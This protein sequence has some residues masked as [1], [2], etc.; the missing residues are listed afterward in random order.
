MF[1]GEAKVAGLVVWGNAAFVCPEEAESAT[2]QLCAEGLPGDLGE[3]WAGDSASGE[4]DGKGLVFVADE[5]N[6]LFGNGGG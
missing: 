3:E 4:G 6:P 5:L 2:I 1:L